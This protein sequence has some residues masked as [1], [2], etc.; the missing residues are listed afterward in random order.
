MFHRYFKL[1][2]MCLLGQEWISLLPLIYTVLFIVYASVK[3]VTGF[4]PSKSRKLVNIS[5]DK[6]KPKIV[7]LVEIEDLDKE[8]TSYCRCWRSKTVCLL[9]SNCSTYFN[10]YLIEMTGLAC[11]MFLTFRLTL[12]CF[13]F[14]CVTVLTTNTTKKMATT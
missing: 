14:R 9:V 8:K 6:E 13:S 10:F 7:N 1:L 4:L 3:S 11:L 2:C 5:I 12:S